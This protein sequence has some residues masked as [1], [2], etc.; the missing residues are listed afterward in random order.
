MHIHPTVDAL[1]RKDYLFKKIKKEERKKEK[2]ISFFSVIKIFVLS[3]ND[4]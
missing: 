3:F 1:R 4:G 2:K